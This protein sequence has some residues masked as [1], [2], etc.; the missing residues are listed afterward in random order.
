MRVR[1]LQ[2]VHKAAGGLLT[3]AVPWTLRCSLRSSLM[4]MVEAAD[5]RPRSWA[6]LCAAQPSLLAWLADGALT[7]G[8]SEIAIPAL[9]LICHAMP[10]SDDLKVARC[11][12]LQ[13]QNSLALP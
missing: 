7:W 9:Q 1:H 3:S 13:S 6:N 4:Q 2:E 10:T 11:A 12:H 5:G 8:G